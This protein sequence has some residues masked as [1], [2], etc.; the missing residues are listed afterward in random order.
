MENTQTHFECEISNL[1]YYKIEEA[2]SD[3]FNMGSPDNSNIPPE[4]LVDSSDEYILVCS[5]KS[6]EF[7][8]SNY[9]LK[10]GT[11]MLSVS[12]R[13]KLHNV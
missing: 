3:Y 2:I 1:S 5:K 8:I 12:L 13:G 10:D 7:S 4:M 9:K 6:G 11:Y